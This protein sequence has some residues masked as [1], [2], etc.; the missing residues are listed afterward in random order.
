MATKVTI[1]GFGNMGK[2]IA[3]A[4]REHDKNIEIFSVD[5]KKPSEAILKREMANSDYMILAV[6][7]QDA[8][9]AISEVRDFISPD[10]II[11]SIMAGIKIS[12]IKNYTG[13]T[14]IIRMM[15]N[16][17]LSLSEGIAVWRQSGLNKKEVFELKK[18]IDKITD[19]FE[20]PGEDMIDKVTAI[21]GSGPAYF[22][23]LNE[24]FHRI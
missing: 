21:S 12:K 23:L 19:N 15:P 20:V 6:K 2:A 14:K 13:S 7:P 10:M 1:L 18:F 8:K 17:G 4:L 9:G 3:G 24:C 11:I 5:L 22:F 16:I